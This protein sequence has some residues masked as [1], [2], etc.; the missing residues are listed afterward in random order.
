MN[1]ERVAFHSVAPFKRCS[2]E[3]MWS[4]STCA[5]R[6]CGATVM[7]RSEAPKPPRSTRLH[8]THSPSAKRGG[9]LPLLVHHAAL[10]ADGLS[11]AHTLIATNDDKLIRTKNYPNICT[12]VITR[13][14][15]C[16]MPSDLTTFA[17]DG[18]FHSISST[19]RPSPSFDESR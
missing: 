10:A 16:V 12:K 14:Q 5:G 17:K 11:P 2:A 15:H 18:K 6:T 9:L 7:V 3:R 4:A 13:A 1:A 8:Q 19:E